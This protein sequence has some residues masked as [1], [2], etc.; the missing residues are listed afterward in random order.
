[1]ISHPDRLGFTPFESIKQDQ[2]Y[3]YD[4]KLQQ[5]TVKLFFNP[6]WRSFQWPFQWLF[7]SVA[8]V[9]RHYFKVSPMAKPTTLIMSLK[10][11]K[12]NLTKALNYK[13]FKMA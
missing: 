5:S 4:Y 9:Q 7:N 12:S 11:Y 3:L 8:L 2:M 1:M 10:D 13:I 6:E